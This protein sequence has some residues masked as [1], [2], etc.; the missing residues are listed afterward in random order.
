MAVEK[1]VHILTTPISRARYRLRYEEELNP[2]QLQA[3]MHHHGAALVIAG[4]GTGKTRTLAYRVAR[5]VEDGV[6]PESIL[7]VTFTRKA[8][9]E[10]LHRAAQLL[11]G[12]CERV[13]GGTF[14]SFAY[15]ILR[16]YGQALGLPSRFTVLDQSDATDVLD[17]LRAEL[18]SN[19]QRRFPQKKTLYDIYTAA[20]NRCS[21][22]GQIV[23]LEYPHFEHLTPELEQLYSSYRAYK[24]RHGL[25]DYDDL[26]LFLYQLLEEHPAI[27]AQI[28]AQFR[29]IMVDEYQD[30]NPL[31]HRISVLL[32]GPEENILAV[33][34]DAQSIYAFR[35]ADIRNI[36]E[37]PHSFRHCTLIRLEENYRSTQP[38]LDVANAIIARAAY[39]YAKRLWSRQTEG[40]RPLLLQ[41][42]DEHQQSLF[43]VQ[44][45]LEFR[46]QG[47]P[48]SEIA[49]LA[50]AS[51]HFVDL[52][53]ELARAG[54]PYRKF[55]GLKFVETAHVKDLLALAR[56]VYNLTD[57][58]SWYR[59]LLLLDGIGPRTAQR[60][61]ESIREGHLRWDDP[62][63]MAALL[64]TLAPHCRAPLLQLWDMLS[65]LHSLLVRQTPAA[66]L[67]H[68][69]AEFYRPI[70]QN[71][72]DDHHRRWK[73]I[74]AV[75]L[76]AERYQ[77]LEEF[78]ADLVLDP[79]TASIIEVVAPSHDEPPLTLS[80][81]HSAK[82]LEWQAVFLITLL[83]GHFPPKAA[84]GSAEAFEEERRL[85]YVACT[86]AKRYLYLLYPLR[87]A[88]YGA[89]WA[90][91]KPSPFLAELDDGLV[92][93]GRLATVDPLKG[94]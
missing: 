40:P 75:V 43:L 62:H 19:R 90:F 42:E 34:D 3:V 28:H 17:L 88:E 80:T 65:A 20:L 24:R 13:A 72:Y 39:G 56:I 91:S 54:I 77:E 9:R 61:I 14:H 83:D 10:L 92:E 94:E 66:E 79:P 51:H 89:G 30:T 46:E 32:A 26:L 52:E 4:A 74:E 29:F 2:A 8:A 25:L 53:L 22:I 12:R 47:I 48:F 5:L 86:R 87:V 31:Q 93:H 7:L 49:V 68:Q 23:A 35:G 21:T 57:A 58:V 70:L 69:L 59:V 85:F 36:V 11:D 78:L 60:V 45:I 6:P 76:L 67:L 1:R 55:G 81:V 41:A 84:Y 33:G 63:S 82:G 38:I 16:R 73:D 15:A 18:L 71:R 44:Q 37:F 27:R 50:R 64:P